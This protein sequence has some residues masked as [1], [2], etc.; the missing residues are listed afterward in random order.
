MVQAVKRK[1]AFVTST[2]AE[3][4][5]FQ[6]L[7]KKV[8][9][10]PDYDIQIIATCA[11]LSPEL[12]LT[13]KEIEND[14]FTITKKVDTLLSSDTST[15]T[16]K[17]LG[18]TTLNFADVFEELKPDLVFLLGDR[19][20]ILGVA[21]AALL[22][23]IPIAHIHGGEL[24]EGA[25]DDSIRHAITKLSN[26]HFAATEIYKNRIIQMGENPS[27]VFNVGALCV[28]NIKNTQLMDKEEL[29]N[30]LGFT[31]G[32]QSLLMTYHP[33]TLTTSSN[34]KNLQQIF[35]ALDH[36]EHYKKI[37][38]FPNADEGGRSLFPILQEYAEK[39]KDN[40]LLVKS[41]GWKRYLSSLKHVDFVIGNSSSGLLEAP[42]F[43]IPTINIGLREEGRIKPQSVI[44]TDFHVISIQNAIQKA[45]SIEFKRS[46]ENM[47]NPYG[48]GNTAEKIMEVVK[49]KNLIDILYKKFYDLNHNSSLNTQ[50]N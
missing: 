19:Y 18:L 3:Y 34:E 42:V 12:G 41:L 44:D 33:E 17:T 8:A 49:S 25:V 7:M 4:G 20:E 14:G 5:L 2:R 11:H 26:I 1:I 10:D 9:Q 39:N 32:E 43:K 15:A 30:S 47:H 27:N 22:S 45:T 48:Q 31:L 38:T 28:D 13:Y 21:Q 23:K 16:I 35:S 29:E 24:T 40:T 36:F 46:I 6:G 37:I 50:L